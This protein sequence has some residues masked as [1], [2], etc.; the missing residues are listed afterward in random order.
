MMITFD[1][2]QTVE[3]GPC[4]EKKKKTFV[5][6]NNTLNRFYCCIVNRNTMQKR[7]AIKL[8]S[9]VNLIFRNFVFFYRLSNESEKQKTL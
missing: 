9:F 2:F 1:L 4:S 5:S 6:P 7:M 3:S 8:F